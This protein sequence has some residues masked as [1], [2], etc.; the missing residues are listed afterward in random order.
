MTDLVID[1]SVAVATIFPDERYH[2]MS[3]A[4]LERLR[5]HSEAV[6]SLFWSEVRSALVKAERRGRIPPPRVHRKYNYASYVDCT[7]QS[8]L[9][10]SIRMSCHLL[11][12]TD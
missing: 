10:M 11:R 5:N 3:I 7:S 1:T 6:P 2:S 12:N 4:V 9:P 8:T